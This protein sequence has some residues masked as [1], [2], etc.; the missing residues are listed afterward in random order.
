M[1]PAKFKFIPHKNEKAIKYLDYMNEKL[2][3]TTT[4]ELEKLNDYEKINSFLMI[5]CNFKFPSTILYP[6][7]PVVVDKTTTVYPYEG[8]KVLLTGSEY[9]L[10]KRQKCV[11]EILKIYYIPFDRYK[12][13]DEIVII[14]P[15]ESII[16]E[17]QAK[18]ENL[19]KVQYRI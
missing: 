13:E 17:I 9:I 18:E 7:I 14:K 1:T 15:F 19:P 6:S 4:E 8:E 2:D 10:A 5:E 16:T 12:E 3:E 11:L